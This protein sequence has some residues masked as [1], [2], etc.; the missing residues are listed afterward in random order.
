MSTSITVDVAGGPAGGAARFRGEFYGY[1]SRTGR[2]DVHVIG[3]QRRVT[4]TWLLRREVTASTRTRRV[5]LNNV[6]FIAPGG[7]RWTL[8]GNALHFLT[9]AEVADLHPCLRDVATHQ[10]AVVRL[11]ARRSD[12]LVAPCSAMA[13]RVARL[14][15]SLSRRLVVRMHP[16]SPNNITNASDNRNILCPVL[17]E[18]YKHMIARLTDWL[19][20]V[21]GHIDPSI[22]L[23]VTASPAEVP[24]AVAG[25]SQ[26]EL[27]GRMTH[28]NLRRLWSRS[29]AVYF[30]SGLESFGFPLAE[31]RAS[32]VPVIAQYSAQN[33]EIASAALCGFN[34][35][36]NISLRHAI[37]LALAT[38][39]APDPAP[40]DPDSY[41]DWMLGTSQ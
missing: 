20:A 33:K 25:R 40:F 15:P 30:P 4:P 19:A 3:T 27:V 37:E 34:L 21:E 26:I 13:D 24:A 10:A 23:V 6:G 32:G 14:L 22:K 39:P 35:G 2:N 16:V 5:A 41:F 9:D 17:F 1:L 8:L 29:R 7:E 38:Q 28:A 18:P 36:D 31:A 11:A 12:V